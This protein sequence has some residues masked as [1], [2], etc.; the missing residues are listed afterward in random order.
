[1]VYECGQP[2]HRVPAHPVEAWL[3]PRKDQDDE[4]D[5]QRQ[6]GAHYDEGERQR[7][8]VP[9]GDPVQRYQH[10]NDRAALTRVKDQDGLLEMVRLHLEAARAVQRERAFGRLAGLHRKL[11]AVLTKMRMD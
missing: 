3:A 11:I 2:W 6:D 7:Q 4:G 10:K 5:R 9:G 8:V 1:M